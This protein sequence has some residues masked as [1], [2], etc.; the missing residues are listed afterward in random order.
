MAGDLSGVGQKIPDR[1]M[2]ITFVGKFE[3][4]I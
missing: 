4:A 1:L 2:K 3:T